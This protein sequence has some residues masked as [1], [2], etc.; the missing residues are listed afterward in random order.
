MGGDPTV[1]ICRFEITWLLSDVV[2]EGME[3]G[4]DDEI[5]GL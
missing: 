1:E 3:G 5:L 4:G 2:G